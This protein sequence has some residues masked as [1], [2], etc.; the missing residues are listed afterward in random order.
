MENE[1]RNAGDYVM[2]DKATGKKEEIDFHNY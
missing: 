2:P 1:G